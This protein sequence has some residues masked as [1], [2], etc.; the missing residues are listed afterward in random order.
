MKKER[1]IVGSFAFALKQD[2]KILSVMVEGMFTPQNVMDF[3]GEY[4]KNVAMINPADYSLVFD[5]EHLKVSPQDM[6]PLLENCLQM[7]KQAGFG[8]IKGN[9]GSS[10]IVKSQLKRVI[11]K[12]GLTNFEII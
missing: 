12:V 2:E 3:V 4:Q 7:Y 9:L 11:E 1:Y 10:V 6:V 8:K 5:A